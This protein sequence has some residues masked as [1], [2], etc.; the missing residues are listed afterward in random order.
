MGMRILVW[1]REASRQ[2]AQADGYAVAA[3]KEAFFATSDVLTLH[4]R[5]VDLTRG[6]AQMELFADP[7]FLR[8][9]KL[10]S[11]VDQLR[12]RY[13]VA[14]IDRFRRCD[15]VIERSSHRVIERSGD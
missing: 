6:P 12:H 15:S 11:A 10:E 8:Q 13:G 1:A 2:K 9:A 3:S 5:L 7:G 14:A 4:L